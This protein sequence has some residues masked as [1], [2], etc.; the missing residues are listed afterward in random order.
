MTGN[1]RERA[2]KGQKALQ[3][4][5]EMHVQGVVHFT[6]K[7]VLKELTVNKGPKDILKEKKVVALTVIKKKKSRKK[8]IQKDIRRVVRRA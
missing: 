6:E 5:K 8:R 7:V 3:T 4:V 2:V 1:L